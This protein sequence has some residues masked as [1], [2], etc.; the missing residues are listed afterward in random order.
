MRF[1]L[2]IFLLILLF[3]LFFSL[4]FSEEKTNFHTSYFENLI[5]KNRNVNNLESTTANYMFF[6]G[7]M[8]LDPVD[9]AVDVPVDVTITWREVPG[10]I[11]YFITLG[12]TPG[13][14]DIINRQA[15]GSATS[16]T[17]PLGLP[18]NT[19]IYVTITIFI[20]N[21]DDIDCREESFTTE[22]VV[23][24]PGCTLLRNP[25]NGS[26]GVS[27][28]TNISW[29]FAP[30]ATAY[31]ISI[32]TTAGGT[33]IINDLDVGN[34]LNLN[35]PVDFPLNTQIF[36]R[37]TPFNENGDAVNCNEESFTTAAL[38][39]RPDCTL[40]TTPVNGSINVPLNTPVTWNAVPGAIGYRVSI[41]LT[42]MGTEVLNN[43]I[44]NTTSI[45]VINFEAN[46]IFFVTIIPF[47]M[48]GDAIGCISESFTTAMGCLFIDPITQEEVN[49]IPTL[50]FPDA[51]FLCLNDVPL[52]IEGPDGFDGYRWFLIND[53]TTETQI[54]NTFFV[55]IFEPG[56]YRL[57][58]FNNFDQFGTIVECAN[59]QVFT[60]TASEIPTITNVEVFDISQ[61]NRIT[62]FVEG[63][64]DY[65][66]ALNNSNGPYQDSP[67]FN[68]VSVGFNIVFVRDRND[69]G[70]V[71][72]EVAVIGFPNFFTP[73][74]DGFNDFWQIFGNSSP[75][76]NG[77]N[78]FIF[79]RFGKLL[80]Q[81]DVNSI[82]WDGNFNGRQLPSTDYWFRILLQDGRDFTGH[83]SLKR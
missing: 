31:R 73:N 49:L 22:D 68:N 80:R 62:I 58:V 52:L 2:P 77:A 78:I 65:E 83:F 11:G 13:G 27:I 24:P 56:N 16:F 28:D 38:I 44:F 33:E 19:T 23:D 34:V 53:N 10:T 81:I 8:L 3:S 69:C 25:I 41:G 64:G 5:P 21:G 46:T 14:N 18:E 72:Q 60:V 59:S 82:G 17:L 75:V 7:A 36:V 51:F 32:G 1:G 61:D 76:L 79:D 6:D 54:S 67:V 66:Y 40:L 29:N 42:P 37:V 45:P 55:D 26:T 30:G 71:S 35:P 74:G 50:D 57:E 39:M 12:S 15:V 4:Q 70:V 43:A 20:P 48:E 63:Q 9:G 47:N